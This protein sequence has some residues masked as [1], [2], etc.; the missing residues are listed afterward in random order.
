MKGVLRGMAGAAGELSSP[1]ISEAIY[2]EATRYYLQEK[3]EQERVDS[4]TLNS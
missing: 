2:T 4:Y 3:V 1:F